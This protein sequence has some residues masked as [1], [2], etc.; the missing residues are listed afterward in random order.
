MKE[1]MK[2]KTNKALFVL[3]VIS[4]A[5]IALEG[6]LYYASYPDVFFRFL[7][8]LQNIIKAFTFKATI[9]LENA[10]AFMLEDPTPLKTVLGYLYMIGVFTAPYCTIA[11]LYK[12]LE[13]ALK[14]AFW[15]R[16]PE[17]VQSI[18]IFG[19]NDTVRQLLKSA[20]SK[21]QRIH[22]VCRQEPSAEERYR[23]I[24][25]NIKLHAFDL[26]KA[27]E[28]EEE[29]L[30][31]ELEI[32]QAKYI[33]LFDDSSVRNFSVMQ[34]LAKVPDGKLAKGVKV[35][36]RCEDE[37]IKRLIENYYDVKDNETAHRFDFEIVDLPQLQVRSMFK[38]CKLHNYWL[39][40]EK[41]TRKK[42]KDW[43]VHLLI[44]GFGKVGQQ[45]LL[46]AMNLGVTHSGNPIWIDV[47]DQEMETRR[48]LFLNHFGDGAFVRDEHDRN[49]FS[50]NESWVEGTCVIRF[51]QMDVRY[52][53]FREKLTEL[54]GGE[55]GNFTYA[56]CAIDQ[57]DT[58][59]QCTLDL[60]RFLRSREKDCYSRVPVIL[61][62][63]SDVLLKE[64]LD[65]ETSK[66]LLNSV[67]A[68]N[69]PDSI[70]TFKNLFA[71]DVDQDAKKCNHY[72]SGM[73]DALSKK[74]AI[75]V[76]LPDWAALEKEW[77][78]LSVFRKNANRASAYHNDLLGEVIDAFE[79]EL[80]KEMLNSLLGPE[81]ALIRLD[82]GNWHFDLTDDQ[83]LER[84]ERPENH[85]AEEMLKA[86]HRRWC[87]YT[88]SVGWAPPEDNRAGMEKDDALCTHP[89]LVPWDKLKKLQPT[90]IKFDL[91]PLMLEY[92][93]PKK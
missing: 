76:G 89:C 19:Y 93:A 58:G 65:K 36:C 24:R 12:L 9:S 3:A 25:K 38:S 23:L 34:A 63:D 84:I 26:T 72:Y 45:A 50:F 21:K 57:P 59:I 53:K 6:I 62:M 47:I 33:L 85:F 4:F 29:K 64:Y 86:E 56:V 32:D 66:S 31:K 73:Y 44:L 42:P 28:G 15:L 81:G 55:P 2:V 37:G 13:R 74:G 27:K 78:G 18:V 39:Q 7:L 49:R 8:I 17:G 77:N 82:Q 48:D 20:D 16:S 40:E 71:E 5:V 87:Y 90:T 52:G 61:R 10:R 1:W 92:V 91:M 35:F 70:L 80:K 14:F 75:S 68:M 30:L 41:A 60:C 79:G 43:R 11:T 88:A 67:K 51:H 54:T 69:T 83:F 46:Q 22:V